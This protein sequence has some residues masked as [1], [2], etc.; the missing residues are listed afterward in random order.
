MRN[1]ADLTGLRRFMRTLGGMTRDSTRVYFTGGATAVLHGWR[2]STIDIDVKFAPERDELFRAVRD[3]KDQLSV[4]VELAAPVDFIP[5]RADWEDRSPFIAR[6]GRVSFHHF[7][8]CAQVLAKIERDHA[9]DRLDVQQFFTRGLVTAEEVRAYFEAI[10]PQLYR[11]PALDEVAFR[12]RVADAL[13]TTR[14]D[15]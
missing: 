12:R 14:D 1:A 13:E 8:F 15:P 2:D 6:E 7:D 3:I 11:Y 4:N 5:V 10:I 9:Q